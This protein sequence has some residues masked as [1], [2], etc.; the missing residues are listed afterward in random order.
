MLPK[1][2]S[3]LA[4]AY[5]TENHRVATHT[6]ERSETAQKAAGSEGSP[7]PQGVKTGQVTQDLDATLF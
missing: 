5:P 3:Y 4:S 7:E 6:W 1:Q 2:A